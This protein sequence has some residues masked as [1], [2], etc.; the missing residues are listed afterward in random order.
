MRALSIRGL[1]GV[2]L[3]SMSALALAGAPVSDT[4]IS[5]PRDA[6]PLEVVTMDFSWQGGTPPYRVELDYGQNNP[7]LL[8][9]TFGPTTLTSASWSW[10]NF[11]PGLVTVQATLVDGSG[12]RIAFDDHMVAF[13]TEGPYYIYNYPYVEFD[14]VDCFSNQPR[15]QDFALNPDFDLMESFIEILGES[16]AGGPIIRWR[17]EQAPTP[18]FFVDRVDVFEQ[19]APPPSG[20][21]YYG[22]RQWFSAGGLL[23][24]LAYGDY[25]IADTLQV[26]G[27]LLPTPPLVSGERY[28]IRMYTSDGGCIGSTAEMI[29]QRNPPALEVAEGEVGLTS[30]SAGFELNGLLVPQGV[31]TRFESAARLGVTADMLMFC[32]AFAVRQ[33]IIA[34]ENRYEDLVADCEEDSDRTLFI[35][36]GAPTEPGDLMWCQQ[37]TRSCA[38]VDEF[39]Q[40]VAWQ[41]LFSEQSILEINQ[42]CLE[43]AGTPR[44]LAKGTEPIVL[45]APFGVGRLSTAPGSDFVLRGAFAEALVP[46]GGTVEIWEI[47]E[48]AV[49][50]EF[51]APSG[52][53]QVTPYA[54]PGS[55]VTLQSGFRMLVLETG[56][57]ATLPMISI[58]ANGFE[59]PTVEVN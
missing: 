32:R 30:D 14:G 24:P 9:P 17:N 26:G 35:D 22:I 25:D 34:F 59:Q 15:Q 50:T 3:A 31:E 46:G 37:A 2:L 53:I 48:P 38:V 47:A 8:L 29:L 39:E 11:E 52:P 4:L 49:A 7:P 54:T 57:T 13:R 12:A 19:L 1:S 23:A 28:R 40:E 58:F 42:R 6:D 56:E 33:A 20:S 36:C 45:Q 51:A 16:D 10:Q 43:A 27:V 18:P 5:G 41:L 21:L 44:Q 55:P